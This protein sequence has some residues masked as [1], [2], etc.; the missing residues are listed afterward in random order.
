MSSKEKISDNIDEKEGA[1]ATH[2]SDSSILRNVKK[3]QEASIEG[4]GKN[5]GGTFMKLPSVVVIGICDMLDLREIVHIADNTSKVLRERFSSE[6]AGAVRCRALDDREYSLASFRWVLRRGIMVHNFTL[7]VEKEDKDQYEDRPLHWA[8]EKGEIDIVAACLRFNDNNAVDSQD[9]YSGKTPLVC[10][11]LNGHTETVKLLLDAGA[12]VDTQ[13]V[14]GTTPLVFAS[15][16]GHT[17][18]VKLL[19]DAGAH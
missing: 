6:I 7:Q 10:A 4:S 11:S 8:C 9:E 16:E 12:A 5:S 17:E 15:E 2:R 14:Y 19:L 3:S 13:D 1:A 18:I